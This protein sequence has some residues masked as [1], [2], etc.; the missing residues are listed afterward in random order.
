[1]EENR[2][3]HGCSSMTSVILLR[4]M[5]EKSHTFEHFTIDP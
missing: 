2:A 5:E 1:M 3:S 4:R